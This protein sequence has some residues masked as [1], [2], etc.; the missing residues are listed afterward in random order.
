[1]FI[2]NYIEIRPFDT[3]EKVN[4]LFMKN[5]NKISFTIGIC[6]DNSLSVL[7]IITLG[8]LRRAILRGKNNEKIKKYINKNY[9]YIDIKTPLYEYNNK[10]NYFIKKKKIDLNSPILI[11]KGKKLEKLISLSTIKSEIK[12]KSVCVIGLGHVGLPFSV[13][14]ANNNIHVK[15][16]DKDISKLNLIKKKNIFVEKNLNELRKKS[17]DNKNLVLE[18]NFKKINAQIYIICIGAELINNK[19]TNKNLNKVIQT[20]VK[21]INS[22]DLIIFRGT[23]LVGQSREISK[24]LEILTGLKAGQ[25]FHISYCPERL[26]EGNAL[27][28][29]R[30][31]PQIVS[32]LTMLC[33]EKAVDFWNSLSISIV[34]SEKFEEAE[35]IKLASNSYRDLIFSFSNEICR[36]SSKYNI[37]ISDLI[38]KANIGYERNDFK[39]ASPGVGGSCLV[40]DPLMFAHNHNG[41]SYRMGKISRLINKNSIDEIILRLKKIQIKLKIKNFKILIFGITYKGDPETSD[42]RSSTSI[43]LAKKLDKKSIKYNVY[44]ITLEKFNM[45]PSFF[46]GKILKN[47]KEI[48]NFN[49]IILMNNHAQTQEILIKNLKKTKNIKFIYDCWNIVPKEKVD[50][51]NYKYMTLSKNYF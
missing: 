15:G 50:Y 38:E 19:I 8:D 25:D 24:K 17:I 41:A 28:E 48:K 2:K 21:K 12:Y 45:Y 31:L 44:D 32:G 16:Y 4:T 37:E 40:K 29:L 9:F 30:K 42:I 34:K 49:L 5:K 23:M 14:I 47:K 1:M 43:D 11:L 7:G 22:G 51:F 33:L 20:F 26:V 6:R 18:K 36:I 35:I 46:K 13:Y 39:K 3:L 10:L 27:E